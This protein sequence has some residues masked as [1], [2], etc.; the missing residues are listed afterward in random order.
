MASPTIVGHMQLGVSDAHYYLPL[1]VSFPWTRTHPCLTPFP[2][3]R[4]GKGPVSVS[5]VLASPWRLRLGDSYVLVLNSNRLPDV[6]DDGILGH[7]VAGEDGTMHPGEG[8][9]HPGSAVDA[10]LRYALP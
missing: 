10:P 8:L 4:C 9:A 6:G 2:V 7:L 3:L 5:H 1:P